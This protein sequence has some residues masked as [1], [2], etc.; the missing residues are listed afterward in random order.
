MTS[1]PGSTADFIAPRMVVPVNGVHSVQST[2]NA[3]QLKIAN[4]YLCITTLVILPAAVSYIELP[5][6]LSL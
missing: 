3:S 6:Y 4:G 5:I 1:V 2:F